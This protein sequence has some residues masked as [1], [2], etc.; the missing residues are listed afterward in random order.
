MG[1]AFDATG[2]YPLALS[3]FLLATLAGATIIL[4]LGPYRY[5]GTRMQHKAAY[6]FQAVEAQ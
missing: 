2:S 6:S 5:G 3:A 4:R 1:A